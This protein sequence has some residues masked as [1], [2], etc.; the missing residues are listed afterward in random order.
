VILSKLS[1]LP[2]INLKYQP[3]KISSKL[4]TPIF[5][6]LNDVDTSI[7]ELRDK[8]S[9]FSFYNLLGQALMN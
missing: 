1:K 8:A 3:I 2:L 9:F 6:Q 7:V 5:F 4:E